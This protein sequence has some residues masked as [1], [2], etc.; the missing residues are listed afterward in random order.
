M[1]PKIIRQDI[2]YSYHDSSVGACHLGFKRTYE[3]MRAKYYW[4]RMYQECYDYVTS[5]ATCQEMKH[6]TNKRNAPL[7][8]YK[9]DAIFTRWH[10]DFLAGLPE[11]K[12]GNKNILLAIDS[13]SYDR[14]RRHE[15]TRGVRRG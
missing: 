7:K 3:A 4:K 8:P 12:T 5:C 11:T 10:F 15:N 14:G 2:L 1:V 9:V 13:L 6:D